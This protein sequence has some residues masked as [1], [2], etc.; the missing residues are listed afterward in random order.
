M[1]DTDST[2]DLLR[3]AAVDF[4]GGRAGR[5]RLRGWVGRPRPVDRVLWQESAALG[6][7]GALL[8]E[9]LGGLGL[10]LAEAAVLAEEAGRHLYAE[11]LVAAA[12]LPALVL[13][14][15][16]AGTTRTALAQT[17]VDGQQLLALAWQETAGTLTLDAP[18]CA[19]VDGRLQGR[20]CFVPG[21]ADDA[22]LLVYAQA[23]G[24]P[25]WVAVDARA[26]GLR[27]T[28][29]AAGLGSLWTFEFDDVPLSDTAP[30]LHGAAARLA[31][32]HTL[33]AGRLLAAAE[34]AGS[35]AGCL[36][37]TLDHLRTRQQ[38]DRTI[39]SFQAVQHR[40]VD[41]HME[42]ELAKASLA[43]ALSAWWSQVGAGGAVPAAVEAAACAAKARAGDAA[44]TVG[45]EA[46]QLHG[47]MGFCE[48]VDIGLYLRAA[49]QGNAWLG[50]PVALRR[51]FAALQADAM[52][53]E[54]AHV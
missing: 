8:P 20:K 49:L 43:Q 9:A 44:V 12:F 21:A 29:D 33:T 46:V 14:A 19:V 35:A 17:L 27:A 39:G 52:T 40:C 38:F 15:A 26:A 6:W 1:S 45:R 10:T 31:L 18:R 7:T 11:P 37:Q 25:A 22:T 23:Q 3:D 50:G 5:D 48:E 42:V 36:A 47:A 28:A 53:A 54:A 2:A 34:L 4:L 30:L 16:D 51:R 24:E 32:T 13:A 41:L